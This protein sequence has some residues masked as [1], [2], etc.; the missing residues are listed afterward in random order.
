MHKNETTLATSSDLPIRL[1]GVRSSTALVKST[2]NSRL[3]GEYMAFKIDCST[4][5]LYSTVVQAKSLVEW[6]YV[7]MTAVQ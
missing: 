3:R 7:R 1:I 4:T 6:V 2:H 5:V